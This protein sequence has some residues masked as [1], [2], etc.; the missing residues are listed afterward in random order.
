MKMTA[1]FLQGNIAVDVFLHMADGITDDITPANAGIKMFGVVKEQCQVMTQAKV[2]EGEVVD[3]VTG[4]QRLIDFVEEGNDC[5]ACFD[6]R[7]FK[8]VFDNLHGIEVR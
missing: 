5:I 2:G 6:V 7:R 8:M 3:A 1:K 4:F